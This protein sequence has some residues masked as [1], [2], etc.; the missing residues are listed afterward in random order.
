M[1]LTHGAN[2]LKRGDIRTRIYETHFTNFSNH[3]D[4]PD[5][6]PVTNYPSNQGVE[7]L[8]VQ[9]VSK[10]F[11]KCDY[12]NSSSDSNP[13]T[14]ANYGPKLTITK[15]NYSIELLFKHKAIFDYS[16][17]FVGFL[18]TL[19]SWSSLNFIMT[20][21]GSGSGQKQYGPFT[22]SYAYCVYDASILRTGDY[23]T[24]MTIKALET[25]LRT[26]YESDF[27]KIK[28][29]VSLTDNKLYIYVNDVL[30]CT[31]NNY[32]H[33][34][35]ANEVWPRGFI[36]MNGQILYYTDMIVEEWD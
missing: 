13:N 6:G 34:S 3:Q 29:E 4:H 36:R 15:N 32:T 8:S 30:A 18:N 31:N 5:I 16:A 20:G 27:T 23:D 28:Y 21:Y 26:D 12:P 1:I 19:N 11:Y 7:T 22:G 2:S 33:T 24:F 9:G 10:T 35:F 14:N 17:C 25:K